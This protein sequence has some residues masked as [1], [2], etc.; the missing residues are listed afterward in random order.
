MTRW[1]SP[2]RVQALLDAEADHAR[3]RMPDLDEVIASA[4]RRRNRRLIAGGGAAG[5]A[6][7]CVVAGV[8]LGVAG[9]RTPVLP[10]DGATDVSFPTMPEAK[11]GTLSIAYGAPLQVSSG[12]CPYIKVDQSNGS[13]PAGTYI[14]HILDSEES[15]SL[16]RTNQ[17]WQVR[18]SAGRV[19]A[20]NGQGLLTR[21]LPRVDLGG[22]KNAAACDSLINEGALTARVVDFA[23]PAGAGYETQTDKP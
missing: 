5:V 19:V 11:G 8:G 17:G 2:E 15:S 4:S 3:R 22:L 1:T 23:P 14:L 20:E 18:T 16:H 13:W 7:A 21:P 10:A 12:G 9:T 6:V